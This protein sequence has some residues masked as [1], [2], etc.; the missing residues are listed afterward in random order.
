MQKAKAAVKK[1]AT[2]VG[3]VS[4]VKSAS[5]TA[6]KAKAAREKPA[7]AVKKTVAK[8]AVPVSKD[9]KSTKKTAVKK[10]AAPA[11]ESQAPAR[12]VAAVKPKTVTKPRTAVQ[13]SPEERYRM[14][15]LA[16]YFIAE[17]HGF[18][19][20]AMAHWVEAE[21]EITLRLAR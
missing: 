7:A 14:I 1:T 2:T 13:L 4:V 19:G 18:Q 10:V 3:K 6:S 5:V 12:K 20:S 17:R 16:A 11:V 8:P 15:E 21:R 9:V